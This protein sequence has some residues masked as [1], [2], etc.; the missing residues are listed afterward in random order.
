MTSHPEA[1]SINSRRFAWA[2]VA[3]LWVTNTLVFVIL[4]L[5]SR[6]VVVGEIR[7]HAMG[8]ALAAAAALNPDDLA[9]IHTLQDQ[10]SEAFLRV[11]Q[12]LDHAVRFNPDVR[13]IYT[14]RRSTV[15]FS[16]GTAYEYIVDQPA[17]DRNRN[18]VL[19]EDE[20][21]E[22]PGQPYDASGFPAMVDAW[23]RPIADAELSSDP[24]YPDLLS[25]YAPVRGP[26]GQTVAIVGVDITAS[27]VQQ[28]LKSLKLMMAALWLIMGLLGQM[29]VYLYHGQRESQERTRLRNAELAAQNELLRRVLLTPPATTDSEE[30]DPEVVLDR[31]DILVAMKGS[32]DF[33]S[34]D[35]D[36]DRLGFILAGPDSHPLGSVLSR[37]ALDLLEER[38]TASAEGPLP[39]LPYVDATR[40]AEALALVLRLLESAQPERRAEAM[41]YGVLDFTAERLTYAAIGCPSPVRKSTAGEV[42]ILPGRPDMNGL[43]E[44]SI[45]FQ[46]SDMIL[47]AGPGAET[48][49]EWSNQLKALL[50]QAPPAYSPAW[51]KTLPLR[52]T[53]L[54]IIR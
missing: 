34:F 29:V 51:F 53:V 21:S 1:A 18:G 8:V 31:Y 38:L 47:V 33:R 22:P 46:S 19:D 37:V 13:Y 6:Y 16:A 52:P 30:V 17:R 48:N 26:D 27:T 42:V 12:Q 32:G 4:F 41:M 5:A 36:H 2:S 44:G 14:M 35:L 40:P 28:K 15:P 50:P 9:Q 10:T 45:T 25:G 3:M 11:Q 24:P 7:N 43:V 20:R 54:F 49:D 39:V 23:D